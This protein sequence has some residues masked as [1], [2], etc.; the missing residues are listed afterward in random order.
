MSAAARRPDAAE[1]AARLAPLAHAERLEA[2][3]DICAA[4]DPPFARRLADAV[5]EQVTA[6]DGP[7]QAAVDAWLT[8]LPASA[9]VSY[10]RATCA[11][12]TG[13]HDRAVRHWSEFF[14][15]ATDADPFLAA[16]YAR[17]Q[18]AVGDW[19]GAAC[20][21]RR[22]LDT[23]PS[24]TFFARTQAIVREVTAHQPRA[25][26]QARIAVLGSTTTGLLIPILRALCVRDRIS[27]EFHEGAFGAFRQEILEPAEGLAA[28]RPTIVVIAPHW[29]DLNLAAIAADDSAAA[30][31][32][33]VVDEY[34]AL[35]SRL[36]GAFD[37]H[38]VQ[39]LF[40]LPSADSAGLL[41]THLAGGRACLIQRVN[42]AL[43]EA[44][45]AGVS[46]LDTGLVARRVGAERWS[47]PRLWYL[48]R[49]HPSA[50]ALPELA[51]EQMAHVRGALGL[52][53]KVVVCDLDNTLW[54][55][56]V[57]EDGLAGIRIGPGSAEGDAYADLQRY[58][59]ELKDRGIVLAVC[60]K[61]DAADARAPFLEKRGMILGIDDFTV[62]LANWEDK[63]TNLRRIASEIGVGLDSLVFLDDNPFER[64]W[65]REQLP[66][67]AVPE[68]GASVFGYV[69]ALD[70]GRYFPVL[71]WSAEDRRRSE[72]YRAEQARQEERGAAGS[73]EEFLAGLHMRA[74]CEPVHDANIDRVTQLTNKTNQFNLTT[75]R[76]THAEVRQIAAA[77]WTGVVTLA[78]R[79][80][81]YGT[82][83]A[84]FA[85]PG[86]SGCW[87]IDTWLMSCRVLRR[88]VERFMLDR[89]IDAAKAAGVSRLRGRYIRTEKNGLVADLYPR[90]GFE[91]VDVSGD[92]ATYELL[93][94]GVTAPLGGA[95]AHVGAELAADSAA[96]PKSTAA[97]LRGAR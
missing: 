34:R 81:D 26:R 62:F 48:A 12:L 97:P 56:I 75:R 58:L 50:E 63:A 60:S 53:R 46:M 93:L 89:V 44:A 13:Q 74:S 52:S 87:E 95:I 10:L 15:R 49:Q 72:S 20:Q 19:G 61:N 8:G 88:D 45:P 85:T 86:E 64:A 17:S 35:W 2:A 24:Y 32:P 1:I 84:I 39:H 37:C 18:A 65:V 57:G 5:L 27:A 69:T 28:F 43:A 47:N 9:T 79:F 54:K 31:V 82:I 25:V 94:A 29:R 96:D 4:I 76:R 73:M 59:R 42:L 71:A 41:S 40:D 11:A 77:G 7:P 36:H 21:L 67:V 83:G 66:E 51:E 14:Q 70:A 80:G 16:E 3:R 33:A 92:G 23:H 78:D 38:V 68:L 55:G 30:A 90:L 6:A 22:A 91:S